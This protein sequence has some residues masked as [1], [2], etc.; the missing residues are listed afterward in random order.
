MNELQTTVADF[1]AAHGLET[2]ICARLLDL[3]SEVGEVA[4]ETLKG[5]AYGQVPF[6]CPP[7]WASELGDVLFSLF[8]LANSTGV[9]LDAELVA[10][11]GRYSERLARSGDAGSGR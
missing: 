3:V 9:D 2:P 5:S 6:E 8:C 10:A 7:G 4:K 11:L 1:V